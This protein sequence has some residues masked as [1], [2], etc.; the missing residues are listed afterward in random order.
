MAEQNLVVCPE[1]HAAN[2]ATGL[3]IYSRHGMNA[4]KRTA[5]KFPFCVL[6][7][8]TA[9]MKLTPGAFMGKNF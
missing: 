3:T 7:A 8:I 4:R 5:L 2:L 1:R 9:S 6:N